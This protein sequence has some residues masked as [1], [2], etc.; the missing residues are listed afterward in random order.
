MIAAGMTDVAA[1]YVP[2]DISL[3]WE[4]AQ[5]CQAYAARR[6]YRTPAPIVRDWRL[7]DALLL[8]GRTRVVILARE[9][10]RAGPSPLPTEVVEHERDRDRERE[11]LKTVAL[12]A[13]WRDGRPRRREPGRHRAARVPKA[14]RINERPVDQLLDNTAR[15]WAAEMARRRSA[16]PGR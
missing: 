7:L 5:E 2:P 3:D 8:A 10:H 9:R 6:G 16:Q 12:M 13:N 11:S 15:R 4:I 14:W 1:I